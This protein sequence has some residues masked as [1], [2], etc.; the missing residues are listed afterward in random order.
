MKAGITAAALS[1]ILSG[2]IAE[3]GIVS[4]SIH[5]S[6]TVQTAASINT[7]Y[8][9]P[10]VDISPADIARGYVE[11]APG[12]I[13]Q[14]QTN[15]PKGYLLSFETTAAP[16]TGPFNSIMITSGAGGT[17]VLTGQAG[18]LSQP[19]GPAQTVQTI[20]YRFQLALDAAPGTYPWPLSLNVLFN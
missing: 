5:V 17:L 10:A 11:V 13:V 1:I 6:V 2:G 14:I 15:D 19:N 8:Q 7:V 16:G 4:A 18:V 9:A 20:N 3:A 12:T